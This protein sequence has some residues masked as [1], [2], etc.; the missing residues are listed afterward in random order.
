MADLLVQNATDKVNDAIKAASSNLDYAGMFGA[1]SLRAA[2]KTH[3]EAN[4]ADGP[5]TPTSGGSSKY[6][7]DLSD[8]NIISDCT[9]NLMGS[10]QNCTCVYH[11]DNVWTN[12]S[13]LGT[14]GGGTVTASTV[15]TKINSQ[16]KF[17]EKVY[18]IDNNTVQQAYYF[19]WLALKSEFQSANNTAVLAN[20]YGIGS[21]SDIPGKRLSETNYVK[22]CGAQWKYGEGAT[23]TWTVPAGAS[24]AKFQAWGA[25]RGSNPACCCGGAPF[26]ITGSYAEVLVKVTPGDTYTVCAGC[27][28]QR[29]CCSNT[30]PGYGCMSGV[31][32]NG[33]CCFKADGSYVGSSNCQAL[34]VVR[35]SVGNGANCRRYQQPWCQDSGACW[36]SNDEYCYA[37]SCST[38]GQVPIAPDCCNMSYCSCTT[39]ACSVTDGQGPQKGHRGI[40]GNGCFDTNNYGFHARPPIINSD[41]GLIFNC[42]LGCFN[43]SFSSNCCCGGCNGKDWDQHPGHGGAYTHTMGG[44]NTHRGDTGKGGMVQISW[45]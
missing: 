41:T 44:N 32:G 42:T 38:C 24:T 7:C 9:C 8:V 34:N 3:I 43:G 18:N 33:I 31:T 19:E 39:T 4:S 20:W 37:S 2:L 11:T 29:Y 27:S 17:F 22:V 30:A 21:V 1:A 12:T 5:Y 13:A 15:R 45:A 10:G 40:M 26:A 6:I 16:D 23:C 36:C 28:C 25:G 35:Q 14:G